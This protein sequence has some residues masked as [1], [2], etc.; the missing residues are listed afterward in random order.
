MIKQGY[1]VKIVSYAGDLDDY[2]TSIT[3]GLS[4]KDAYWL[5][6]FY[7][8]MYA[9]IRHSEIDYK[10]DDAN[11]PVIDAIDYV[12]GK[13]GYMYSGMECTIVEFEEN[14][15]DI[16]GDLAYALFGASCEYTGRIRTPESI[17]IYNIPC[18]LHDMSGLFT[19]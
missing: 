10:H 16:A 17:E 18:D 5:D 7:D 6:E 3:Q 1:M 14:K 12:T 9:N 2:N 13:L 11:I 19:Q 8:R 4:A 15:Q